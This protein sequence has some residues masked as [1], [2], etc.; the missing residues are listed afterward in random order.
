MASRAPAGRR[1]RA[2]GEGGEAGRRVKI[3]DTAV[4]ILREFPRQKFIQFGLEHSILDELSL[5]GYLDRHVAF[6]YNK[7]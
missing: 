4:T 1:Q 5:L 3:L 2:G 7:T 6:K